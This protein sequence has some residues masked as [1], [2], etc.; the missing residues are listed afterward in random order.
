[1]KLCELRSFNVCKNTTAPM[2]VILGHLELDTEIS[3]P[4]MKTTE[5]NDCRK[6]S[7]N[8]RDTNGMLVVMQ[9]R[10]RFSCKDRW[11]F[12]D[13]FIQSISKLC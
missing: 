6:M 9:E 12:I 2:I 4:G 11:K 3:D 10:A 7:R 1:M 13:P 8:D 5:F